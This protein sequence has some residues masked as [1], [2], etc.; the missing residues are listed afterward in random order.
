M[1]CIILFSSVYHWSSSNILIIILKKSGIMAIWRQLVVIQAL[2]IIWIHP[3]SWASKPE[4]FKWSLCPPNRSY[5]YITPLLHIKVP[6]Q[7]TQM[8]NL[9]INYYINNVYYLLTDT[10]TY[11]YS[12]RLLIW[13]HTISI[14]LYMIL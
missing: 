2:E 11:I 14:H 3:N 1:G 10:H 13:L 9:P 7:L 6:H 4:G 8:T 5:C 12:V